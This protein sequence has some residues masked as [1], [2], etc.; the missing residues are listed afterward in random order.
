VHIKTDILRIFWP[1]TGLVIVLRA[2]AQIA[3]NFRRNSFACR[4]LNLL[5]SYLRL[6]LWRLRRPL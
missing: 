2:L 6:F 5:S 3:V 1:R 4:K